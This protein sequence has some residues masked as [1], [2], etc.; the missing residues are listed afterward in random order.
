[1]HFAKASAAVH[2]CWVTAHLYEQQIFI[3]VIAVTQACCEP[4]LKSSTGLC[5]MQFAK[6][7]AALHWCWVTAHLHEQQMFIGVIAVTQ[8]CCEPGLQSSIEQQECNLPKPGLQC[9]GDGSVHTCMS[10]K[11]S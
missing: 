8:A 2:W 5:G 6:T 11:S 7:S 4:D 3:G 10:S 9:F 1:M